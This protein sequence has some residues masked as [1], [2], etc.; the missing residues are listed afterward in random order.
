MKEL[1]DLIQASV[2]EGAE[3]NLE[4][5]D[6]EKG[7]EAFNTHINGIIKKNTSKELEKMKD[8]TFKTFVQE[9]GIEAADLDAVKL[10]VKKMNGNTDEFKEANIALEKQLKEIEEKYNVTVSELDD[11][12]SKAVTSAQ[13]NAIISKGFDAETAELLQIKFSR[14]V[15]DEKTFDV[16][17]EEYVKEHEPKPDTNK[18]VKRQRKNGNEEVS[19]SIRKRY[20]NYFKN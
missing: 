10:W 17:L 12:K 5:F 19:E 18:F 11:F 1:K 7:N 15:T 4:H 3:V 8:E 20:P 9:V 2:K 6:F 16:V 13:I 14:E